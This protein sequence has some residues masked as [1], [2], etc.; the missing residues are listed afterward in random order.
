MSFLQ[1]GHPRVR[2][3]VEKHSSGCHFYVFNRCHNVVGTL[4]ANDVFGN[5]TRGKVVLRRFE[6]SIEQKV[7]ER[8]VLFYQIIGGEKGWERASTRARSLDSYRWI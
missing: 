8:M 2:L 5:T 1:Q 4:F 6:K 7:I 3:H